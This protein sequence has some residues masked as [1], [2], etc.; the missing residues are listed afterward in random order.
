MNVR[1]HTLVAIS[2]LAV[3][4]SLPVLAEVTPEDAAELGDSLTLFGA[5]R[6]GNAE[7]TIPE[8]SG[9]LA[10]PPTGTGLDADGWLQDPFPDDKPL[11][12][13]SS[14]NVDQYADKLSE[15]QIHM[16]KTKPDYY[17]DIYPSRRTATYPDWVL[18]NTRRNATTC[19]AIADGLALA[20]EC[21][22]GIPFPIPKTGLE[23]MWNQ[24]TAYSGDVGWHGPESN[25]WSIDSKGTRT[26]NANLNSYTEKP[27]WMRQRKD[28]PEAIYSRTFSMFN[29]PA[30]D[31]GR[32]ALT[33]DYINP[34]EHPRDAWSYSTGQRRVRKAPE[35]AYDTPNP[36]GGGVML[37]DEVF[38]FSGKLDRFD[39]TFDG[40][41]EIF[42]PY[43]NYR[44]YGKECRG[45][46]K[47]GP[48]HVNPACERWELHR[49]RVV[50]GTLKSGMRH[51]YSKRRYYW[52]ED[53]LNGGIY[54]AWDHG[55]GLYRYGYNFTA[56]RYELPAPSYIPAFVIYDFNRGG[57][58]LQSDMVK[59]VVAVEPRSE[60]ELSPNT[61]AGSGVR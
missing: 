23:M 16:L 18:E 49:V 28:K 57:Y 38:L 3:A 22:G 41:K 40:V 59:P 10:K 6:A 51:T 44:Y 29:G 50:T 32:G 14:A 15:A 8:Y 34:V 26:L 7:G 12:R 11:F 25:F 13:I 27:Y 46:A 58:T 5:V 45:D 60:R 35:F 42:I 30:R 55:G 37:Y 19:K 17:M 39:W 47:I 20:P 31:A 52:D 48:A 1:P 4:L 43:N 33:N 21:V 9:G 24:L 61:L 36:A 54:E 53:T 56:P 2:G